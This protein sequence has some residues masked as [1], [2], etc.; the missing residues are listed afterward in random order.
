MFLLFSFCVFKGLCRVPSSV[1][2]RGREDDV[3]RANDALL[4]PDGPRRLL[5]ALRRGVHDR[6]L[7]SHFCKLLTTYTVC[8]LFFNCIMTEFST[9]FYLR[10]VLL[11]NS[12][13]F[14]SKR[15]KSKHSSQSGSRSSAPGR[16]HRSCRLIPR[17]RQ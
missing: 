3:P 6:P 9:D 12:S 10:F 2:R 15:N 8:F 4:A 13:S 14:S 16:R 11:I 7:G 17:W 5:R 1:H